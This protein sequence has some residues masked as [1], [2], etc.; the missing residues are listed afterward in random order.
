MELPSVRECHVRE[1][2]VRGADVHSSVT[3]VC[4]LWTRY[5]TF[6]CCSIIIVYITVYFNKPSFLYFPLNENFSGWSALTYSLLVSRFKR[7]RE[8]GCECKHHVVS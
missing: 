8:T 7:S 6:N 1:V 4:W 3:A 5:L 2:A